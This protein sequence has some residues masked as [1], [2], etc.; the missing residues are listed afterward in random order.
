MSMYA[1]AKSVGLPATF[2]E[3]RH[4]ATH[5]QLPSLTRLRAAAEKALDWIY[6]YYWRHLDEAGPAG[7][8]VEA[9]ECES[10]KAASAK[11]C[12][13]LLMELFTTDDK[14]TEARIRAELK[15]R[16]TQEVYGVTIDINQQTNSAKVMRKGTA[17]LRELLESGLNVAPTEEDKKPR[18]QRTAR[19][20]EAY[21]RML[22]EDKKELEK[23]QA[24]VRASC[25]GDKAAGVVEEGPAWSR[26]DKR[27]WV[28]KPIGLV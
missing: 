16:R 4:Q 25:E 3:L 15:K 23:A 13:A 14:E 19:D 6:D 21:R 12:R 1:V 27:S 5:E 17:F 9:A 28:P 2:V 18:P 7:A 26:Y 10:V 11:A 20:I 22:E 8:D 24:G